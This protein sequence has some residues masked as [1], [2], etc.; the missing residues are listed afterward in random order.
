MGLKDQI[1]TLLLLT[2]NLTGED[3]EYVNRVTAD[4]RG[5]SETQRYEHVI[6]SFS[7]EQLAA[8]TPEALACIKCYSEQRMLEM[9]WYLFGTLVER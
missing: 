8:I 5:Q 2:I 9:L 6:G 3:I 7:D 1:A 4:H